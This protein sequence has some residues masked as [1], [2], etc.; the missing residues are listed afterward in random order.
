MSPSLPQ[1]PGNDFDPGNSDGA[2]DQWWG[3]GLL[4]VLL[5][6]CGSDIVKG[7]LAQLSGSRLTPVAF[8]FGWADYALQMIVWVSR[9]RALLPPADWNCVVING[10]S[11]YRRQNR[12]WII[13]R[14]VRDFLAWMDDGKSDGPIHRCVDRVINEKWETRRTQAQ[15]HVARPIKA[16]LCVSVYRSGPVARRNPKYYRS[17]YLT[18]VTGIVQ[19]AIAAIPYKLYGDWKA[20]AVTAGGIA[21]SYAMGAPGQWRR[22]KWA[23]STWCEETVVLTP[24]NGSQHAIVVIG[25]GHGSLDLEQLASGNLVDDIERP[26][27]T[28][29]CFLLLAVLWVLLLTLAGSMGRTTWTLIVIASVG[30]FHNLCVTDATRKPE[31]AGVPLMFET[32]IGHPKVMDTLFEVEEK[33]PR[34]GRSMLAEF[35]PGELRPDEVERWTKLRAVA[36]EHDKLMKEGKKRL[37]Y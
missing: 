27:R 19:L 25:T 37:L 16:G 7:A 8:S 13:G 17:H 20:L 22:E 36:D 15:Q 10:R 29:L 2:C 11:G 28:R 23:C 5:Q 18:H 34:L 1:L 4:F 9:G 6:T 14:M 21:L 12:S 26:W 30:T 3:L 33:Y 35:F 31:E 32:V 24:G